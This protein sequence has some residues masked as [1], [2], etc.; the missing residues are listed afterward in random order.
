MV[1]LK[2]ACSVLIFVMVFLIPLQPFS[3]NAITVKE[4]EEIGREFIKVIKR[5]YHI[6]ADPFI[7]QYI[8][9][10]GHRLL[11]DF[12]PQY[13]NYHFY[14]VR[15]E[16]YNA[17]AGPGAHVFINSGLFE[18]MDSEEELVGILSHEIS[19]V[20]CRH[21]S[22]KIERS[23]KMQ[24]ATLAGIAAG[25]LLGVGGAGSAA[26][27]V[28]VSTMAAGQSLSLAYSRDDERQADEVGLKYMEKAGYNAEGLM[29][30]LKKIRS[31]QWYGDEIP[32][33]LTTHPAANERIVYLGRH[34]KKESAGD[35]PASTSGNNDFKKAHMRILAL[36]GNRENA[37]STF[38]K[39]LAEDATSYLGNH[40]MG[41]V[42]VRGSNRKDAQHYLK[43]ALERQAF[44][45]FLLTDLGHVYYHNGEF[46]SAFNTLESALGLDAENKKGWLLLGR[47]QVELG[48]LEAATGTFHQLITAH[49]D[50]SSAYYYLGDAY[51]R[52]NRSAP[53]HYYL[54]MSYKIQGDYKKA[55]FNLKR[56]KTDA[57]EAEI[58]EK[59][60]AAVKEIEEEKKKKK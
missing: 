50:F 58:K 55:L 28:T 34:L 23:S 31:K 40:G 13:L 30:M 42:L 45:P 12:P 41:L 26:Q 49:P 1:T 16:V 25:I 53:E 46:E 36:Y 29:L 7:S 17:F 38:Q 56:A 15:Q 32:T 18:A 9:K 4:E 57:K 37:V 20:S 44:D 39:M 22:Q 10:V 59:I 5:R 48:K 2:K 47:T 51:H 24:M 8:E 33:Y 11:K 52:L 3:A 6:I 60:D 21:I 35:L 14:V 27:A 54:G 19:H 43:K